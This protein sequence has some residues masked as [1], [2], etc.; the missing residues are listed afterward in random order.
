MNMPLVQIYRF[1]SIL[2]VGAF[3][4]VLEVENKITKVISAL[5]VIRRLLLNYG[6]GYKQKRLTGIS[7]V[8]K[9]IRCTS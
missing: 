6:V 1:I 7:A 2:G 9:R 8:N 4:V 3:G 5:K